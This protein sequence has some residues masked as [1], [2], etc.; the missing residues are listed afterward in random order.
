[1]CVKPPREMKLFFFFE[2][3]VTAAKT[4]S[5][6]IERI[7]RRFKILREWRKRRTLC[8]NNKVPRVVYIS[9][10]SFTFPIQVHLEKKGRVFSLLA[11]LIIS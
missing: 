11:V 2:H 8:K 7:N 4:K 5:H 9:A 1:M 10:C 6:S 3:C